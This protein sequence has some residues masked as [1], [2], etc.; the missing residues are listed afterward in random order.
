V[1]RLVQQRHHRYGRFEPE[2]VN[3]SAGLAQETGSFGV[4]RLTRLLGGRIDGYDIMQAQSL[5]NPTE[6]TTIY[7][8]LPRRLAA[9]ALDYLVIVGYLIALTLASVGLVYGLGWSVSTTLANPLV[10]DGLTFLTLVLPIILYF[11][12]QESSLTQATWGKRKLGLRVVT[13]TGARLSRARGFVRSLLKFLPWQLAHTSI[14]HIPGWPLA[15]GDLTPFTMVGLILVWILAGAYMLSALI[16]KTHRTPYDWLS[17]AYV[18][19]V[20][21]AR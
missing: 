5:M 4:A 13:A 20:P 12:L 1:R 7:A 17:G 3:G 19:V 14:Y 16:S 15:S 10:A 6:G 9:F 21:P 2:K 18:V 11:S 8:E